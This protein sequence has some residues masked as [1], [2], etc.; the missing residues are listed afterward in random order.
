MT[1]SDKANDCML[2][3]NWMYTKQ[4]DAGLWILGNH[5]ASDLDQRSSIQAIA[6]MNSLCGVDLIDDPNAASY[7]G[8]TGGLMGNGIVTPLITGTSEGIFSHDGIPDQWLVYGGCPIINDFDVLGATENGVIAAEYPPFGPYSN[9]PSVIQSVMTNSNEC[10]V[11]TIWFGQSFM[12]VRDAEHTPGEP[13]IRNHIMKDI[14]EWF[15]TEVDPNI[16]EA[17][18]PFAYN[19]EQNHPNP[20]NPSTTIRFDVK[21]RG[22]V[23]L[24][25]F[26]VAGQLV[27]TLVDG[28]KEASSYS[29]PWD[30]TNNLGAKVA[31]GVYFYKMESV[32]FSRTKK[33]VLLR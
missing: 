13:V 16:T 27:K 14:I 32:S 11:K 12:Y 33:L 28:V 21:E 31:S 19:L 18:V 30:G 25:I 24:K 10:I 8:L 29:I 23:S 15:G 22:H 6:L 26:N 1:G 9:L 4:E 20:F 5:V 3:V 17:A 2:L 7:F